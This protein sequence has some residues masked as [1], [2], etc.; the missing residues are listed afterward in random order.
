M[1]QVLWFTQCG[2]HWYWSCGTLS[3]HFFPP[4]FLNVWFVIVFSAMELANLGLDLDSLG[5]GPWND[6]TNLNKHYSNEVQ[7]VMQHGFAE[8]AGHRKHKLTRNCQCKFNLSQR[9]IQ[10]VSLSLDSYATGN[11]LST[12]CK[13]LEN[14]QQLV[15][16]CSCRPRLDRREE[17]FC[18]PAG[19]HKVQFTTFTWFFAL[20]VVYRCPIP[21]AVLDSNLH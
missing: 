18:R 13:V 19:K 4:K 10:V 2:L 11:S 8:K 9:I 21:I 6:P 7:S 20:F 14:G 1:A 5:L 12:L 16:I 17:G 15:Q 3:K